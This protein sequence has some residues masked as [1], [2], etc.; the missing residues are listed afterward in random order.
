MKEHESGTSSKEKSLTCIG[1]P[2]GCLIAVSAD[3]LGQLTIAGAKCA[4]GET[5]ARTEMVHPTRTLTT[6]IAVPGSRIPLS[7]KT[8]HPIPRELMDACL[9]IIHETSVRLP[10]EI[11]DIVVADLLGTG[12]DA[13]ATRSLAASDPADLTSQ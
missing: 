11:G 6:L 2:M 8:S 4:R 7:V 9:E 3:A 5:Y 13:I 10:V 1:C 12:I